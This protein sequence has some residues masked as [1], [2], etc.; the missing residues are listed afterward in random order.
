MGG[1][2]GMSGNA[3]AGGNDPALVASCAMKLCI[4]PVFDC[5]LQGCGFAACENLHCIIK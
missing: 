2:A 1:T 4:D 5:V 3:G